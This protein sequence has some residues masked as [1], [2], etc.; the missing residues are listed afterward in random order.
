MSI[1]YVDKALDYFYKYRDLLTGSESIDID[2]CIFT[3]S[4]EGRLRFIRAIFDDVINLDLELSEEI[5][6]GGLR[7]A[8][9]PGAT[10]LPY[11]LFAEDV[12]EELRLET[13]E[14]IY[15][16]FALVLNRRCE[17]VLTHC[18]TAAISPWNSLC[19]MWWELLPR[20]GVPRTISLKEVDRK[21]IDILK[22]L[23][24]LDNLACKE[25]ALHGLGLW[26][27]GYPEDVRSL[28]FD[29]DGFIPDVLKNYADK[30]ANGDL[31]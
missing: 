8:I 11:S 23:I 24:S 13:I 9:D 5:V 6:L 21:I 25:S 22:K 12:P 30:A 3:A 16:F 18:A 14:R 28:I 7:A 15:D 2:K 26:Q 20:H 10:I 19:F 1:L 31:Q 27:I 17:S 4:N 29:C